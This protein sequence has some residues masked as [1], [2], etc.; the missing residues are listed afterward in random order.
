MNF[1]IYFGH[2]GKKD[3]VDGNR[4]VRTIISKNIKYS[5]RKK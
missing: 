1:N 5:K 2:V 3:L 4:T